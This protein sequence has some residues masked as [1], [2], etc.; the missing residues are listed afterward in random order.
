MAFNE[1]TQFEELTYR[2]G[3]EEDDD[4]NR[5]TLIKRKAKVF[6]EWLLDTKLDHDDLVESFLESEPHWSHF[7][8]NPISSA[9]G[10][11][12]F[13]SSDRRVI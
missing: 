8:T 7:H 11:V 13:C 4:T 5:P 1:T 2:S 10:C 9:G 3:S 12:D 6:K